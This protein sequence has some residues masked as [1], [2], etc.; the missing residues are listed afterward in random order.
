MS[1]LRRIGVQERRYERPQD[2]WVCGHL[3]DGCPCRLGPDRK[4]NCRA[5]PACQ[6]V[7][8]GDRWICRRSSQEGGPC[9]D[10]P[11]PDGSCCLNQEPCVPKPSLRKRRRRAAVWLTALTAGLVAIILSGGVAKN[12]LM[13]GRLAAQHANLT[14]C[15]SCHA[16]ARPQGLGWLH[17]LAA[18]ASG[19][20]QTAALCTTCHDVGSQPFTAHT[21]PVEQLRQMTLART[22]EVG[23]GRDQSWTNRIKFSLPM[24]G[25]TQGSADSGSQNIYCATCHQE[26][27]G[28]LG[29]LTE[30]S[31]DRCQTCH[32]EKFGRFED[33][34]PQ[35]A[36][37]PFYQRT[38]IIFDHK[39]HFGKHFPDTAEKPDGAGKVPAMC[40]T[41]HEA[42]NDGR[43]M[44]VRDFEGM[45]AT[46]HSGDI[47]GQTIVSGPK[48]T[49]FLSVPGLDVETLAERGI[50][51]GSWPERSEAG[52]TPF[53]RALLAL[54]LDGRDIVGEVSDLDLLDLREADE[55]ALARV[56][57]LAWAV[58]RL[59]ANIER[60]GLP[61]AMGAEAADSETMTD[62]RQ[63]ALMVGVMPHDVIAAANR[64]WLPDLAQDLA[65]HADGTPTR[66]FEE[67]RQALEEN[68]AVQ[69]EE[70]ASDNLSGVDDSDI[71]AGTDDAAS[72]GH[73]TDS[74]ILGGGA[75]GGAEL[76]SEDLLLAP[77]GA[78]DALAGKT[79]TDDDILADE[80]SLVEDD[81]AIADDAGAD[82]SDGLDILAEDDAS[83]S[84]EGD[85]LLGQ[86][87][88]GEEI[89]AGD[90]ILAGEDILA[91]DE[92]GTGLLS[93]AAEPVDTST[94]TDA[95]S[96]Q[97]REQPFDPENWALYGGWY[98]QDHTIRY[99][100][101]GHEDPFLKT[102]L[103]YSSHAATD[104]EKALR[105]PVFASLSDPGAVG[106]CTKCHSVDTAGVEKAV[107][108]HP[109][110]PAQ[111]T[112]RF[113][114]FSHD[115]HISA[116]GTEG[117]VTCH[118]L[119]TGADTYLKSYEK[120]DPA[121]H[122]PN[123]APID[124]A[125]C[126]TCHTERAAGEEC[127]LCHQYHTGG[128]SLPLVR[129]EVP[130]E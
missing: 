43:Y 25:Q 110:D 103:D 31:N 3:A 99:R 105:D 15:Q 56:Q 64:E 76:A 114:R 70:A 78:D 75:D 108:W 14:D 36:G 102:W 129:T 54:V 107:R 51:V 77:A 65:R 92:G 12:Y 104:Q 88:G 53:M 2:D 32:V 44:A 62:H 106:R 39:S 100:P 10:G 7:Q 128:F 30:V 27:Q 16:D 63:M 86:P 26:H 113:T 118:A 126:A 91:A 66:A 17:G 125:T 120:G 67:A 83:S 60:D 93:D 48:G 9:E 89:L 45:C 85:A 40:E 119:T 59:L 20:K 79:D 73:G 1:L 84:S 47:L 109:F 98:R 55:D 130:K 34:H 115:P 61:A 121:I 74:L 42:G 57:T 19:P 13:P 69:T 8:D 22:A 11:L 94:A 123:F 122:A 46:C 71:L 18:T 68:E 21:T 52:I 117:C 58:K 29:K 41:C 111:V 38:S 116:V 80:G 127:T 5:G 24:A 49:N 72:E 50:D 33:S 28:S 4:G 97:T 37:Y 90:D 95:P 6:P 81:L 124:K 82:V 112:T 101:T 96:A 35:F 87:A 23:T